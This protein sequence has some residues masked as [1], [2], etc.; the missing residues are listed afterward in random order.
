VRPKTT[1]RD[2]LL[3]ALGGVFVKYGA[4]FT[5]NA[6]N[7]LAEDF[8][9]QTT[10]LAQTLVAL[11]TSLPEVAVSITAALKGKPGIAVGNVLGSNIF[12]TYA[13]MSIPSFFGELVISDDTISFYLPFM[14]ACTVL[15]AMIS[16]GGR[17]TKWEGYLLLLMY[18]Y[19]F[20]HSFGIL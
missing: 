18:I 14:V 13:V 4:D 2:L 5:V 1:W 19:F 6:I 17:I 10:V 20:N 7:K 12:N 9:I 8:D 11:G 15:F 3:L 16:I